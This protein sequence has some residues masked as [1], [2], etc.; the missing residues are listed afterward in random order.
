[1]Q[2]TCMSSL[3]ESRPLRSKTYVATQ[4]KKDDQVRYTVYIMAFSP[5]VQWTV[6]VKEIFVDVF[7]EYQYAQGIMYIVFLW[8]I[9]SENVR[10]QQGTDKLRTSAE[11]LVCTYLL[12][13]L[14][15]KS[16][17]KLLVHIYRTFLFQ[18]FVCNSI[19]IVKQRFEFIH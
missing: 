17:F 5:L 6:C 11:L 8:I 2:S 1:M 15:C 19:F 4:Q 16:P 18:S 9:G 13:L 7:R 3:F 14:S 10:V 12:D